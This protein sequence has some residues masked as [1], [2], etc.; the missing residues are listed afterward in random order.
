MQTDQIDGLSVKTKNALKDLEAFFSSLPKIAI[1][2]S[3][4]MDSSLLALVASKTAPDKY[5]ALLACS[6]FMS[7]SEMNIARATAEK[8]H[9]NL[10]EVKISALENPLVI[11][12]SQ[13]RCYHCKKAIFQKLIQEA[14]EATLCEGSVT[15]DDNDYR[16]GKKALKELGVKSPLKDCGF[17]K[18][19]VGEVLENFGAKVLIRPAQSCLAT[20][21]VTN[22]EI[23]QEKLTQIEDG[24]KLLLAAGL[25]YFRLRHHE[26]IARIE[27]D[28]SKLHHAID[29]IASI[30]DDLKNLGFKHITLDVDGYR[31]GSM[32][33]L[34]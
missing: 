6:E 27:V 11:E 19:M 29:V 28:P 1:A 31:K 3:G 13:Q 5:L 26:E 4:G 17:S 7:E 16:P 2:Y 20:R 10:K 22:N 30:S 18:Q 33:R 32:N 8:F 14:G 21:I 23:S 34:S 9:F 25:Q 24:E 12:N 15:D